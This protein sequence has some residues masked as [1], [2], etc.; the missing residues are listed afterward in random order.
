MWYSRNKS[1]N[2][3]EVAGSISDLTQWLRI[4]IAVS[5]GVGHRQGLDPALLWLWYRV[6]VTAPGQT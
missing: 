5:C 6:E 1:D 3:H 2:I 4:D